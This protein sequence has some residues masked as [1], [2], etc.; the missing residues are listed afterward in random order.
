MTSRPNPEEV[1]RRLRL[2]RY[3]LGHERQTSMVAFL[4]RPVTIQH[5][6]NWERGRNVPT[7]SQAR[8]VA[9]KTRVNVDWIYWGD[10][11]NLPFSMVE[12]LERTEVPDS[13]PNHSAG[14]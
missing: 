9:M 12:L 13:K 14:N 2:L 1:G 10:K 11:A 3:A 5:W 7:V 6:N 4:G 8:H